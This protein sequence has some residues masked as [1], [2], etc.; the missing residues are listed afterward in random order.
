MGT[1]RSCVLLFETLEFN[2]FY[3]LLLFEQ[4]NFDKETFFFL[5]GSSLFLLP[6]RFTQKLRPYNSNIYL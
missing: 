3:I 6:R 5:P 2:N 4:N 1:I